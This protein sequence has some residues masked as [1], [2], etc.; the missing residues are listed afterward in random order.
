LQ[1]IVHPFPIAQIRWHP[2][3]PTIFYV[4]Y[5]DGN[6]FTFSTEKEDPPYLVTTVAAPWAAGMRDA[7][8]KTEEEA[9]ARPVGTHGSILGLDGTDPASAAEGTAGLDAEVKIEI[10]RQRAKRAE[11]MFIWKNEEQVVDKKVLEKQHGGGGGLMSW[12]GRNPSVVWKVG[13]K[14]VRRGSS[15]SGSFGREDR[16]DVDTVFGLYSQR[17]SSRPTDRS[18]RSSQR[19]GR[20][21][22]S[23]STAQSEFAVILSGGSRMRLMMIT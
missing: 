18:W 4:L 21:S 10:E 19:M 12:A 13:V 1:G 6:I 9:Q 16:V 14:G 20:S 8:L 15:G 7:V 5:T 3:I 22:S 23:T 11:M 17:W 2:R